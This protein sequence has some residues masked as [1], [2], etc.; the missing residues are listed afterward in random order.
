MDV[1]VLEPELEQPDTDSQELQA[2]FAVFQRFMRPG[3][4]KGKGGTPSGTPGG[5][6]SL[7]G[8]KGTG[9]GGAFTG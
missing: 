9:K 4:G 2:A 1:G 5:P 8:A 3:K 6:G 7:G